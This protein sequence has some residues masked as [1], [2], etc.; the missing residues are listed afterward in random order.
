MP[1]TKVGYVMQGAMRHLSLYG[2]MTV[3]ELSERLGISASYLQTAMV[4]CRKLR[5]V[6]R[7]RA[8]KKH[9][10]SFPYF[11]RVTPSGRR[12]LTSLQPSDV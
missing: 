12:Y 3:Y 1:G 2:D 5:Y 4:K 6:T 9:R 7:E 11:Y 8:S 10:G